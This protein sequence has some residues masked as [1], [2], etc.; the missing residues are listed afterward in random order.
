MTI[1]PQ[2]VVLFHYFRIFLEK[3]AARGIGAAPLKGAHLLTSVYPE[4]EDRG[5][6]A[7]VDFLVKP[8]DWDGALEI[9][10]EMGFVQKALPGRAATHASFY[11]AG[12]YL[13]V[14]P[15]EQILFEPHRYL[16]Q[17]ARLRIDYDALWA[18][19]V[20]STF[21]G[22]PCLRLCVEDHIL[23]TAVHLTTHFFGLHD[24][25]LRDLKLLL[26]NGAPDLDVVLARAWIWR[27][28]RALWL[29]FTLLSEASTE[30][31]LRDVCDHLAPSRPVREYLRYWVPGPSGFRFP[32]AGLRFKEAVLWPVVFD[33]PLHFMRFAVAYT[34]LRW[35]DLTG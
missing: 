27:V 13:A 34:R 6:M 16:V 7:D 29:M 8:E 35:R 10:K 20:A 12:F 17:P 4:G 21:D 9:L 30:L 31:D 3:A 26:V 1:N 25:W 15:R 2:T 11:E 32:G 19:S 22:A 14:T 18:R 5:P 24:T 28:R 23:Y 33:S